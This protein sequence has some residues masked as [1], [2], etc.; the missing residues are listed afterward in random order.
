MYANLCNICQQFKN[1]KTI[2]GNLP[3]KNITELKAW[4][5]VYVYLVGLYRK[6]IRQ[7]QPGG[8]IIRKNVNLTRMTM[9]DPATGWFEIIEIP[10][11]DLNKVTAGN[12]EYIDKSS[13]RVSQLF[14]KTWLCI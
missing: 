9:N 13:A 2:Y 14:N 1:R 5:L 7:H 12:D 3:S 6:S 8:V 11:F 10:T 4:D